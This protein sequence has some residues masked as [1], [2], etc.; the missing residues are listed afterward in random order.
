[1]ILSSSS[2]LLDNP[3]ELEQVKDS[4]PFLP[5]GSSITKGTRAAIT[6][7]VL[8]EAARYYTRILTRLIRLVPRCNS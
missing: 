3:I 1:L 7:A 4:E 2:D 6:A 8:A 5:S